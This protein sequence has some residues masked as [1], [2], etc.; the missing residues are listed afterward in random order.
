[1]AGRWAAA[2]HRR[3]PVGRPVPESYPNPRGEH[4]PRG[5]RPRPH[6]SGAGA[7]REQHHGEPRG[8]EC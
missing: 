2:A 7:H 5:N 3:E 1:L 6:R 4:H 8:G